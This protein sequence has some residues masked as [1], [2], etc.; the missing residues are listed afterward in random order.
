MFTAH[1]HVLLP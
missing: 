1:I